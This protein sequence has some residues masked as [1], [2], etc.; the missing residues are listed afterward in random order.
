MNPCELPSWSQVALLG[1]YASLEFWLGRTHRT[2]AGSV[3]EAIY[4][5][6]KHIVLLLIVG[7]LMVFTALF[8]KSE[9]KDESQ[10]ND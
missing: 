8:F 10:R 6:V 5:G 2:K 1:I 3:P 4:N 9:H 7:A